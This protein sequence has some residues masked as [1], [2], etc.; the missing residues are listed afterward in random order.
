MEF[1]LFPVLDQRSLRHKN[2]CVLWWVKTYVIF[3]F[4]RLL[5]SKVPISDFPSPFGPIF[6]ILLRHFNLSHVLSHHIHKPPFLPSPFPLSEQ[7]Y[8]LHHFPNIP[9]NFPPNMLRTPKSYALATRMSAL[10]AW[11]WGTR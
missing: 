6:C 1:R 11:R 5:P 2:T 7:F 3:F 10:F 8:P 4:V 9:I